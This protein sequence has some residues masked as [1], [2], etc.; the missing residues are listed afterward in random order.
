MQIP[1]IS[2]RSGVWDIDLKSD[3]GLIMHGEIPLN[4]GKNHKKMHKYSVKML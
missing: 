2:K 3:P 4:C 1:I